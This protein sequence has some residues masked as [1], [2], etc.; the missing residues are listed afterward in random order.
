MQIIQRTVCFISDSGISCVKQ[1][2][3]YWDILSFYT[4]LRVVEAM[5][6]TFLKF[7]TPKLSNITENDFHG[8]E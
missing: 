3:S 6:S 5:M 1:G 2:M 7:E 8:L 4:S